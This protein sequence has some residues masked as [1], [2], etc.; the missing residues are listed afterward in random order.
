MRT[1]WYIFQT[2]DGGEDSRPLCPS[3][4]DILSV[5]GLVSTLVKR[6]SR[7]DKKHNLI[8]QETI[9]TKPRGVR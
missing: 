8:S 1:I 2:P 4:K 9:P 6:T 7:Y 5:N 3:K